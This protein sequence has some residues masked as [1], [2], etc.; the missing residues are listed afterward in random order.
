MHDNT[1][2]FHFYKKHQTVYISNA[3]FGQN[4]SLSCREK[5]NREAI[6]FDLIFVAT[7]LYKM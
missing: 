1:K 3:R 6:N 4:I 5:K 7:L 2:P